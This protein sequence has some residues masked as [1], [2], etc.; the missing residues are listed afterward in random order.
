VFVT[1]AQIM[2]IELRYERAGQFPPGLIVT[3][4]GDTGDG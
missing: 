2:R 4:L 3:E 1:L